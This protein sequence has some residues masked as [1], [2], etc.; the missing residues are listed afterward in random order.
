[1]RSPRGLVESMRSPRERV[2]DCKIQHLGV[3]ASESNL[4]SHRNSDICKNIAFKLGK[5]QAQ[6][7]LKVSM[8]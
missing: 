4:Y 6:G 2:G 3:S 7:S 5:K 8:P 1:M